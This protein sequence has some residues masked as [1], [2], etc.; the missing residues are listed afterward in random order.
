MS[1][2]STRA[3]PAPPGSGQFHVDADAVVMVAELTDITDFDALSEY[4]QRVQP[5]L[6]GYGAVVLAQSIGAAGRIEGDAPAAN[7]IRTVQLWPSRHAFDDF[8]GSAVYEP[9]RALRI[10][11]CT[12]TITVLPVI[13]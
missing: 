6:A 2:E 10:G 4:W 7:T 1:T 11:A 13:V 5:L 3:T 9:I 8:W 12:S